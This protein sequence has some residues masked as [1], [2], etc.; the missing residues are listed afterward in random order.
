MMRFLMSV[1]GIESCS[2]RIIIHFFYFSVNAVSVGNGGKG[3]CKA[4][5]LIDFDMP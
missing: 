3:H 2:L 1:S 5:S 4:L